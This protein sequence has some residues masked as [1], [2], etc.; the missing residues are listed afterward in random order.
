MSRLAE[1]PDERAVVAE[2]SGA[3]WIFLITGTLWLLFS[4]I[5]FRFDWTTVS[6]IAILFGVVMLAASVL[7]AVAVLATRGWWRLG[8]GLLAVAFLAIGIIAFVHPGNTFKALAAVISFYFIIKGG[9]DI[10]QSIALRDVYDLW[11]LLL[12]AGI[13]EVVIGFWAAGYFGRSVVLLV[14]WVG[15]TALTRG[16][17]EIMLAFRL[18]AARKAVAAYEPEPV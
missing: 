3:W 12:A 2:L 4:I 9:F 6:G 8:H 13:A 14:V 1:L 15:V 18:H 5:V 17:T 10:I 11:W 7:E 16:I